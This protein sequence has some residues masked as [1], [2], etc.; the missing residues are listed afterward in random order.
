MLSVDERTHKA[1]DDD[2]DRALLLFV[3]EARPGF[4][5]LFEELMR[6]EI[7]RLLRSDLR[8]EP[9]GEAHGR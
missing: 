5:D 8:S 7:E 2:L 1:S 9:G 3:V 4:E 6:R